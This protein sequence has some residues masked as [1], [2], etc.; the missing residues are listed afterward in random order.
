MSGELPDR[1]LVVGA[2]R[3][4]AA[5]AAALAARGVEVVLHDAA[6]GLVPEVADGVALVLGEQDPA[7]LVRDADVLVKSPGVP[8]SAPVVQAARAAGVP[9]WSEVEVGYRLLPAGAR[10]VGITGTNGK[11]TVTELVGA[12][13][14]ESG[15]R[16]VVA[17]NVGLALSGV[18]GD[19]PP[20]GIVVCELSSFQLEDVETLRC[21]AAALLNLTPDHLDRHGTM[22]E[23]GRAKLRIFERQRPG[24]TA[25]LN[26]DDPWVAALE[27]LPG[28]AAIVRTHATEAEALGFLRSRLRGV[29]NREN[30]AVA[31]ALAR[32]LDARNDD[33]G[34]AVMGFRPVPHRL[35][36]VG[37]IGGVSLWNDSKATNVDATLKALTAF[38]GGALRIILGGSD[39]GA[40][41]GPLA[42][43]LDGAVRAAYLIGPA[44]RRMAPLVDAVVPAAVCDTLEPALDAALR[45]ARRG[46]AILLAPACASFDEFTSYEERG[47]RFRALAAARGAVLR[48]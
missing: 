18:A 27:G 6:T 8:G 30:V 35:E 23:Y 4:G 42:A 12:M 25:V 13:L 3:S 33:I 26:D 46:E 28:E 5:V 10:L 31:A 32:A 44:G 41:F 48:D 39:K 45:D 43:A 36:H 1:A 40:D 19:V 24:D 37:D 11:T 2:A 9:V 7:V 22:E 34:R 15:A 20:D 21:D 38:P 14:A 16:V 47:D 29:H 17:G